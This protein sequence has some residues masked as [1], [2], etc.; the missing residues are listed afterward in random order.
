MTMGVGL[1]SGLGTTM[2]LAAMANGGAGVL[3]RRALVLKNDPEGTGKYIS[4]LY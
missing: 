4:G 2:S 3:K 1:S